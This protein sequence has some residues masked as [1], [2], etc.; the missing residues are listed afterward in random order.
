MPGAGKTLA[1][2]KRGGCWK[3][4]I[5]HDKAIDKAWNKWKKKNSPKSTAKTSD[6]EG[7]PGLKKLLTGCE[8]ACLA[9]VAKGK[10]KISNE[11]NCGR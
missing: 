2:A 6:L 4:C 10:G 8:D 5:D 7:D 11:Q 1:D 3:Y 9:D